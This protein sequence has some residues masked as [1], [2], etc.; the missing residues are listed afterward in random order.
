LRSVVPPG[1][2]SNGTIT[3]WLALHDNSLISYERTGPWIAA[4]QFHARYF[5]VGPRAMT[6]GLPEDE[7]F[8]EG[9]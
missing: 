7:P 1:Q 6:G 9:L 4:S 8:Y 5:I 2:T 3:F